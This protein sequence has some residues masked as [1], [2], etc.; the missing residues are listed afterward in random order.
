MWAGK[1]QG[2]WRGQWQGDLGVSPQPAPIPTA[3]IGSLGGGR[4]KAR[5]YEQRV[6]AARRR[7]MHQAFLSVIAE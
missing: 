1:W 7:K 4:R 6:A 2:A 3:G 5:E